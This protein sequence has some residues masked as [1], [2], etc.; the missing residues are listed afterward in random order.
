MAK[1]KE[2]GGVPVS[3]ATQAITH[4][5]LIE[6]ALFQSEERFRAVAESAVD[7]IVSTNSLGEIIYFNKAALQMFGYSEEELLH[8][9]LIMLL[10]ERLHEVHL[11]EMERF[12]SIRE[13]EI[14]GKTTAIVG[15][16]KDETEF[17]LELSLASWTMDEIVCFTAII[18]DT[19]DRKLAE[20]NASKLGL[21]QQREDFMF[22]LTHDLKN[23]LI[24]AN[25]IL[26]SLIE[27][28]LGPLLDKQS[29]ILKQLQESNNRV[30][31]LIQ[32]LIEIYRYEKYIHSLTF[33]E[34]NI[35]DLLVDCIQE[36]S[37]L[38]RSHGLQIESSI[39][40][41]DLKV[42]AEPA[43]IR[44]VFHN[45]LDNAIRF[46]P[47]D[48][49]ISVK[50]TSRAKKILVLIQDTGP[51]I[52]PRDRQHLFQRFWQGM[53][54]RKYV[55]G[56]GLGLY[57]CKQIVDAHGGEISCAS[58]EGKGASFTVTLPVAASGKKT[59]R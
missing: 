51:G 20:E 35:S 54:G 43:S 21:L 47:A 16:R 1:D 5:K 26:E 59:Q 22:T 40:T 17:P 52:S 14:V 57:L 44:R 8:K 23:P 28:H 49:I 24:G 50:L 4:S 9:P 27:G 32:N 56:T 36:M 30:I 25:R 18:R 41:G 6:R 19:S 48:G 33:V 53:A 12:V 15:K 3:E 37:P 34:T 39:P 45:L 38:A 29:N 42:L 11:R 13:S 2:K 58:P 7:A 55:A 10:P 46:T 31:D